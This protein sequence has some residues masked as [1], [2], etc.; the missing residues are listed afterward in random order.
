MYSLENCFCFPDT[1]IYSNLGKRDHYGR[2]NI[3][4]PDFIIMHL[5]IKFVLFFFLIL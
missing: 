1:P 3:Y 4:R 5:Y 2:V